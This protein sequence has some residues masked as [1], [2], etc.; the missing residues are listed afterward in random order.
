MPDWP[1]PFTRSG[2]FMHLL[3]RVL[4]LNVTHTRAGSMMGATADGTVRVVMVSVAHA[5][6]GEERGTP[7]VYCLGSPLRWASLRC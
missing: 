2:R 5:L 7:Y 6:G 4:G 3:S 1:C